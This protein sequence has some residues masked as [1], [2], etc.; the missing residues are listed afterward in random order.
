M[1]EEQSS[2]KGYD[3]TD[4]FLRV[5]RP[6]AEMKALVI[7]L[8]G[9][10]SHSG[11]LAKLGERFAERGYLFYA[12]DLRG[13]GKFEGRLGHVDSF[14]EYDGDIHSLVQDVKEKHPSKKLFFYGHSLGA[15]HALL[16][17]LRYPGVIDGAIVP[18]PAV[19]ERL[20]VSSVTRALGRLLSALNVKTYI[21]NGLDLTLLA[22][23]Q[24]LV[25]RNQNDPLR[26][27][28]ATPRF[29]MEGLNA[30]KTLF[31]SGHKVT[32]PLIMQQG[33]EDQI[34]D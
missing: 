30:S 2:Y 26:F 12:P 25:E 32:V 14:E 23:N 1:K 9:L 7:G 28:K 15:V 13:F 24:E 31:E 4:M 18:Y 8:H 34:L 17:T 10:G 11:L 3:G 20:K 27:D 6:D 5:I 33:G 19:S 29:A 22:R 16:F 21:D